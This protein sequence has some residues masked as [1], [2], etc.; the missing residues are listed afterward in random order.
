[1]SLPAENTA[2]TSPVTPLSN[3]Y[4]VTPDV[5][6]LTSSQG[7][8]IV[9]LFGQVFI[10]RL[11]PD[12]NIVRLFLLDGWLLNIFRCDK[13]NTDRLCFSAGLGLKR[14]RFFMANRQGRPFLKS[15]L[16]FFFFAAL[17]SFPYQ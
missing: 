17:A 15:M 2:L 14:E 9:A 13:T 3:V 8:G 10:N 11:E 1:M 5:L 12:M 16:E 7:T 6:P 4:T